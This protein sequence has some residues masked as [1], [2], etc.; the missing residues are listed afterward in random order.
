MLGWAV[1]KEQLTERVEDIARVQSA[2]DTDRQALS[3]ELIND[4]EHAEDFTVMR[5]VLDEV[6]GPDMAFLGRPEPNA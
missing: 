2:F 3:G 5:P 1:L 4:A 6:I